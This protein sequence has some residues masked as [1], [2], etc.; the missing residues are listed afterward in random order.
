MLAECSGLSNHT[1]MRSCSTFSVS[2]I[3]AVPYRDVL[4]GSGKEFRAQE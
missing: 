4:H 2:W 3:P 1:E